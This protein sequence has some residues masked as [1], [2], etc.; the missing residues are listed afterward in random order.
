MATGLVVVGAGFVM[1]SMLTPGT[2]YLV[3]AMPS[4]CWAQE[5]C[6][7][8]AGDR[9]DHECGAAPKAG[10]GSAVNDTTRELGVHSASP[11]SAA[12]P[13]LRTAHPSTCQART[14]A[15]ARSRGEESI[16]TAARV[17]AP[18][19]VAVSSRSAR[20]PHSPTHSTWRV[21]SRSSSSS[22]LR[23]A[24]CSSPEPAGQTNEVPAEEIAGFWLEFEPFPSAPHKRQNEGMVQTAEDPRIERSRRGSSRPRSM[25]SVR[26]DTNADHRIRGRRRREEHHLS[27]LVGKLALVEDAFRTLSTRPHSGVSGVP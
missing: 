2:P 17:A 23:L 3:L 24:S 1:L 18:S 14:G 6:H 16:G 7:G 13:T 10:V 4:R 11:S 19:P 20:R 26:S 12:S 25:S 9:R 27:A 22:L 5:W 21:R 8:R 15:A